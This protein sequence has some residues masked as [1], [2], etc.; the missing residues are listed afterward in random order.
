MKR[1]LTEQCRIAEERIHTDERAMDTEENARNTLAILQEQHIE[2]MTVITSS[3]HQRRGQTLYNALAGRFRQENG[4]TVE[5][6]GNYSYPVEKDEEALNQELSITV[7]QLGSI[8]D[9]SEEQINKI[10]DMLRGK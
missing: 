2:T 9:V 8:L 4:Y 7:S 10:R 3:Y 1:Y 5:L 6:I